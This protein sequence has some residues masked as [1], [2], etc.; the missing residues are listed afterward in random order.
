MNH[1]TKVIYYKK[2]TW[3]NKWRHPTMTGVVKG[4]GEC[5]RQMCAVSRGLK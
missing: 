4:A 3:Y 5:S 1:Q 2:S